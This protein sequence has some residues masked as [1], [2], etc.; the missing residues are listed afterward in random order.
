MNDARFVEIEGVG[1]VLFQRSQRARKVIIYVR[2]SN[3]VRVAVPR[4]MKLQRA[5]EFTLSKQAWVQK[6]QA[7]LQ[8][9]EAARQ[10][11]GNETPP[12]DTA[13]ARRKL[14]I[15]LGTL[16]KRHGFT[17]Q[18]VYIRRQRTRWGS[19]SAQNNISLNIR[20]VTLPEPL[21]DYVILHE[22]THTRVKN[23]SAAF[24]QELD[25]YVANAKAVAAQLR[26]YG[27]ELP[28]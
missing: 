13:A 6:H 20:L 8:Q 12:I 24:W 17:Y 16:A 2:S 26:A 19:C 21:M 27:T 7:R 14:K 22:L 10:E 5:L 1:P 4:G 25:K 28:S 23:H 3:D 11:T 15:R 9:A 18:R